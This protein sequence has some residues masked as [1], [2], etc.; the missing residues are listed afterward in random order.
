[1]EGVLTVLH[2]EKVP[3]KAP[4]ILGDNGRTLPLK[5]R[6][7]VVAVKNP[8][9]QKNALSIADP[10]GFL[11]ALFV[12]DVH[13]EVDKQYYVRSSYPSYAKRLQK[14]AGI[15]R[16]HTGVECPLVGLTVVLKAFDDF[17]DA[18]KDSSVRAYEMYVLMVISVLLKF[19]GEYTAKQIAR[20]A[21]Q[22]FAP[23]DAS[24]AQQL[25]AARRLHPD[26]NGNL[27]ECDG[28]IFDSISIWDYAAL[29]CMLNG[30][31]A[32]GVLKRQA[33]NL[34]AYQE[35]HLKT[36]GV[37][38]SPSVYPKLCRRWEALS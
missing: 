34:R 32:P 31:V 16:K 9:V 11:D 4:D 2:E 21:C 33:A 1:M 3:T 13:S 28:L 12:Q 38:A 36:Y 24:P 25:A 17:D 5:K 20:A 37:F 35:D 7:A 14:L 10:A 18:P 26:Q 19:F 29:G 23:T 15:G 22:C 30:K 6:V 27:K 8:Q